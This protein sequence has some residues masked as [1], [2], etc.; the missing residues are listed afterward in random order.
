M[1]YKRGERDHRDMLAYANPEPK[2]NEPQF[3]AKPDWMVQAPVVRS[4]AGV[5]PRLPPYLTHDEAAPTLEAYTAKP[6]PFS[7]DGFSAFRRDG[8][9]DTSYKVQ[10]LPEKSKPGQKRNAGPRQGYGQMDVTPSRDEGALWNFTR[11]APIK[12]PTGDLEME[13][14]TR[15]GNIIDADTEGYTPTTTPPVRSAGSDRTPAKS[16]YQQQCDQIW[17]HHRR[18]MRGTH[19]EGS[20]HCGLEQTRIETAP[21]GKVVANQKYN[22]FTGGDEEERRGSQHQQRA[23]NE[24]ERHIA[25]TDQQHPPW[26]T[27]EGQ[28]GAI[29]LKNG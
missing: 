9:F 2:A 6:A 24:R 15:A 13:F 1:A 16:I 20:P 4:N 27:H 28:E 5:P 22:L 14:R 12:A 21:A 18:Q 25:E 11:R 10:S 23:V 26:A 7:E 8:N 3:Y 19:S 17:D 29:P